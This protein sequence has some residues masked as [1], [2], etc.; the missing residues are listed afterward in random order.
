[1][2]KKDIIVIVSILLVALFAFLAIELTIAHELELLLDGGV[3]FLSP[4]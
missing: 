3:S 1:M 4:K 2:K